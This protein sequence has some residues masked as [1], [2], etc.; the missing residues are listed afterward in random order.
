MKC[1]DDFWL[2]DDMENMGYLFEYCDKFAKELYDFQSKLD[3]KKL[4]TAFM[5]SRF[6]KEMEEGHPRFLSQAAEDSFE[7]WVNVDYNKDLSQF[8]L[9]GKE[10]SYAFQQWYWVGWMYAFIHFQSKKSSKFIV[11]RMPIDFMLQSYVTGHQI[12]EYSF[13][14]KAKWKL[15]GVNER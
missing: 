3:K 4:L 1:Y 6:R 12:D 9:K 7:M 11:K 8:V 15:E 13:Y 2:E 5:N 14:D 10:E